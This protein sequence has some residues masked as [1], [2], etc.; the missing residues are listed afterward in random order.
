MRYSE[1]PSF[2]GVPWVA[3]RD[4]TTYTLSAGAGDKTVYGVFR[5]AWDPVGQGASA[6]I[7]LLGTSTPR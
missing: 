3:F 4:S 2:S 7:T 6:G 5:N 1:D